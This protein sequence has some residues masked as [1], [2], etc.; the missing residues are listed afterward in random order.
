MAIRKV[1]FVRSKLV[2]AILLYLFTVILSLWP[3]QEMLPAFKALAKW[4]EFLL[5]Y[6]FVASELEQID[7]RIL[8]A[9][10]LLAGTMEGALGIYS[11]SACT[12][13]TATATSSSSTRNTK[14]RLGAPSGTTFE[15][16]QIVSRLFPVS[17]NAFVSPEPTM[18]RDWPHVVFAG[19]GTA[20]HLYPALATALELGS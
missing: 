1:G 9:L 17:S 12:T 16:A 20:G 4:I 3:A 13:S 2:M 8:V 11:V 7:R 19:G 6:L 18:D 15:C 14:S 5:L 10:L